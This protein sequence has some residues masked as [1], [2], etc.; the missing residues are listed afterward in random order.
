ME[1]DNIDISKLFYI[2][3]ILIGTYY[4]IQNTREGF[5]QCSQKS[6]NDGYTTY[7]FDKPVPQKNNQDSLM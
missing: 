6:I 1:S 5:S 7:V 2:S 4:L 3:I